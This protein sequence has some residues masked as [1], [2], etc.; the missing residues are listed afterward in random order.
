LRREIL[1][2]KLVERGAVI[3]HVGG[4]VTVCRNEIQDACKRLRSQIFNMTPKTRWAL[5]RAARISLDMLA[6]H[7][8]RVRE[9]KDGG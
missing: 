1:E 5:D 8:G 4:A 6:A 2:G 9:E 7:E 3:R